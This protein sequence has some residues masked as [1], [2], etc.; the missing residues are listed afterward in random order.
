MMEQIAEGKT[1]DLANGRIR[2]YADR[3]VNERTSVTVGRLRVL[4]MSE[5]VG[6][7]RKLKERRSRLGFPEEGDDGREGNYAGLL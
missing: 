1:R 3:T 5:G 4:G 2:A 6:V 7:W